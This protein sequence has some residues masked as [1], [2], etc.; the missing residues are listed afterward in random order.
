MLS[1]L[2]IAFVILLIV[3]CGVEKKNL[4]MF[5]FFFMGGAVIS[6]FPSMEKLCLS[7]MVSFFACLCFAI[8][9]THW[10]FYG[11][12]LDDFYKIIISA[13]C[14]V[15]LLNF[16]QKFIMFDRLSKMLQLFGRESL[17]IYV[18]QF[19]LCKFSNIKF[20]GIDI[21]P[22]ILFLYSPFLFLYPCFPFLSEPLFTVF[23]CGRSFKTG[24]TSLT[25]KRC[26]LSLIS[27]L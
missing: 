10:K 23:S 4:I 7:D 14:F 22:L 21:N 5:S 15:T 18:M 27:S 6:L 26:S 16:C 3:Y 17:S 19:Y 11:G 9:A 25:S 12:L 24:I 8:L 20:Q 1:S 13:F 2:S